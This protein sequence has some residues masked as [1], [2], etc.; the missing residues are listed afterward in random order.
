MLK[1]LNID[2]N[3]PE[4]LED[5]INE[6]IEYMNNSDKTAEDYYLTEIKMI[7]NWCKRESLLTQDQIKTIKDYYFEAN[8]G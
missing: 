7:L 3:I 5:I 8:H 6:Y 2:F 1:K 4:D